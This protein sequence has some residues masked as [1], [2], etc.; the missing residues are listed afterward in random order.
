MN[1]QTHYYTVNPGASSFMFNFAIASRPECPICLVDIENTA[2]QLHTEFT[3]NQ[4]TTFPL[5][6]PF[7]LTLTTA[8]SATSA[9]DHKFKIRY[10]T[11]NDG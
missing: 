1:P 5:P 2:G 7:V 6:N 4:I 9:I 11:N 3:V 8:C 10:Q